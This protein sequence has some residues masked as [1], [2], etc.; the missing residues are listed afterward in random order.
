MFFT[1]RCLPPAPAEILLFADGSYQQLISLGSWAFCAPGLGV[2]DAGIEAG[3]SV[4][5]FEIK[6]VLAGLTKVTTMDR[7][8]RSIRIFSDSDFAFLFLRHAVARE[9]L[10]VRRTFNR[11]SNL[12]SQAL[13]LAAQRRLVLTKVSSGR[14]EHADCHR[15]A[16]M[17]LR[18]EIANDSVLAWQL[19]LRKEEYRLEAVVKERTAFQ[20]RLEAI[21][22][23]AMLLGVRIQALSHGC[24]ARTQT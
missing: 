20:L 6:A 1:Q 5:Y 21:E 22:E 13:D 8:R 19:T 2:E 10:P 15:R 4:E 23:Q 24:P 18:H 12:Y 3:P 17:R 7:T 11:V 16:A 9:S 14:P